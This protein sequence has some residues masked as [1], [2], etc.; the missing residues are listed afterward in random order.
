MSASH[1]SGIVRRDILDRYRHVPIYETLGY[2]VLELSGGRC[3]LRMPLQHAYTGSFESFH[4]GLM[5][6]VADSAA[7]LAVMGIG[8]PE[9]QAATTD[10]NIRFLQPC[11]TDLTAEATVLRF[12]KTLSPVSVDLWDEQGTRVAVAQVNFVLLK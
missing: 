10:M 7:Y 11:L 8:G 2:Q 4:G 12:G 9:T 3:R 1:E 6:T 5:M